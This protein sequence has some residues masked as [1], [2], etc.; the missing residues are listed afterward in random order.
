MDRVFLLA[1]ALAT[2][3]FCD[4]ANSDPTFEISMSSKVAEKGHTFQIL[5]GL[6]TDEPIE[7]IVISVTEPDGFYIEAMESPGIAAENEAMTDFHSVLK[8]GSLGQK[9][10]VTAV[11]KV[12]PPDLLGNPREGEKRSLYST[13]APKVFSVNVFYKAKNGSAIT[14]RIYTEKIS[15]RYTTSIGHYILSGLFG[16]LLGFIV[17]IATQ[18]KEEINASL[19]KDEALSQ[20][21]KAFFIE[22][23][24]A[25]FPLLLTLL[26]IGF[27]LLLSLAKDGLPVTSW[28]QAIALGIGIGLLSDEQL[29]T[30]IK[31]YKV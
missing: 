13:R 9:S 26:I 17:K 25:R 15:I 8:I 7:D 5:V 31:K 21:A 12:W 23:F 14:E 28:H 4:L 11:F 29:I 27:G 6:K 2:A 18:Y 10:S 3:L 16:V 19:K 24:L 20:K 30:K 1:G 22:V